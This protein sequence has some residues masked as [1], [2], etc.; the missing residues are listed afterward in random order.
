[1]HKLRILREKITNFLPD[2]AMFL[3]SEAGVLGW[4]QNLADSLKEAKLCGLSLKK[5]K[6]GGPVY[7]L[8]EGKQ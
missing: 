6:S 5:E 3:S 1:M 2:A 4:K 8:W 7:T